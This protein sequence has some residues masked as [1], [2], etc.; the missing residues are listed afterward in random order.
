MRDYCTYFDRNYLVRG[1]T[2][3]ASLVRHAS[4]FALWVLCFDDPTYDILSRLDL[5]NLR[6]ISLQAFE[7]GDEAL[8]AAKPDRNQVEYYFTCTP[9]WLLYLLDHFPALR[10]L[11]YLDA[12]LFFYSDP[13]PIYEEMGDQSVLLVGHRFPK[14]LRHREE[15]GIYN[16][17][18]LAFRNDSFAKECLHWW[19]ERCLEWCHDRVEHGRFADQKYLD[20][21]PVR[22]RRV[23][24]LQHK[25]AGL[26]PWNVHNHS[27]VVRNGRVLVDC[28]PLVFFHF[29][30]FKQLGRRLYDPGLARYRAQ[31]DSVLKRYV[32][33]P[34]IEGLNVAAR[35]LAGLVG[36]YKIPLAC[37]RHGRPPINNKG[38]LLRRWAR[39]LKHRVS[40]GKGV[41]RGDLWLVVGGRIL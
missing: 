30:N 6:P 29:H 14:E 3:Y 24:A 36:Q 18:F 21:W 35:S 20:D 38:T 13:Q 4:P 9:S 23:L 10:L 8:L 37:S 15:Y 16:V 12:D 25:G 34:Y 19:R 27:L 22:F 26:A 32:Y 1:L 39:N 5:P 7:C 40:L 33:T 2:L 11:T 31:A 41:C 28:E 17:G